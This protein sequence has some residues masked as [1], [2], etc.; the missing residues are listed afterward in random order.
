[1]VQPLSLKPAKSCWK[2]WRPN[3]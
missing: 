1:M 3:F 2:V